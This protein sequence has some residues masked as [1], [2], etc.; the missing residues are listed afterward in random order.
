M[1]LDADDDRASSD[2]F[3]DP[4]P[5]SDRDPYNRST[6]TPKSTPSLV[7]MIMKTPTGTSSVLL[8]LRKLPRPPYASNQTMTRIARQ[9]IEH[10]TVL[11]RRPLTQDEAEAMAHY[12]ARSVTIGWWGG[13]AGL[14][15]GLARAFQTR[16]LNRLPFKQPKPKSALHFA[17]RDSAVSRAAWQLMRTS[18]Y[19]AL[20]MTVGITL[21][22]SFGR[23]TSTAHETRD[24]RL[25]DYYRDVAAGVAK[26][27]RL[28]TAPRPA[29]E[30]TAGSMSSLPSPT[31]GRARPPVVDDASSAEL[32]VLT[33]TGMGTDEQRPRSEQSAPR[34]TSSARSRASSSGDQ[35]P[36]SSQ[37][38]RGPHARAPA[39]SSLF[40]SDAV[41]DDD[42]ADPASSSSS[43]RPP[44][45]RSWDQIRREAQSSSSSEVSEDADAFSSERSSGSASASASD[46]WAKRRAA[47]LEGGAG[48]LEGGAGSRDGSLT[49]SSDVGFGGDGGGPGGG[50]DR[51]GGGGVSRDG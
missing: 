44:P 18:A 45:R 30:S 22:T 48:S 1:V 5:A 17:N 47:A 26:G 16:A 35:P 10:A 43:H 23:T 40:S 36:G 31:G 41:F 21:F 6:T 11:V 37:G 25:A 3:D 14:L 9:Q 50:A 33:W 15:A 27:G 20:G 49:A 12:V 46:S 29:G 51:S 7:C 34:P 24:P 2:F 19:G 39:D 4:S 13:P 28:P 8:D 42:M 32:D 38:R